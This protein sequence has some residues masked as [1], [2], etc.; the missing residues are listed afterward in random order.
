MADRVAAPDAT[1]AI[2]GDGSLWTH[3]GEWPQ[4]L[5][6]LIQHC[7]GPDRRAGTH[8]NYA[9]PRRPYEEDLGASAWSNV[10]HH[11]FPRTRT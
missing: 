10:T 7:L 6:E 4:A 1:M 5:R 8:S 3:Q 11:H 9:D 2:M